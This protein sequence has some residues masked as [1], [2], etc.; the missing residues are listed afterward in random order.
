MKFLEDASRDI[1][2]C[3]YSELNFSIT[4]RVEKI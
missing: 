2:N 4:Y 1:K 3:F